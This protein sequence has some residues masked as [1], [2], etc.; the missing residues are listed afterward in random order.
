M[1]DFKVNDII[2]S[3]LFDGRNKYPLTKYLIVGVTDKDITVRALTGAFKNTYS[4]AS[5]QYFKDYFKVIA[6]F[7]DRKVDKS[8]FKPNCCV[9][10]INSNLPENIGK[11]ALF[12]SNVNPPV[13][14]NGVWNDCIV[15]VEG[16]TKYTLLPKSWIKRIHKCKRIKKVGERNTDK[17]VPLL[18]IFSMDKATVVEK[19][20][21]Y[22]MEDDKVCIYKKDVFE[23][24]C[25]KNDEYDE[26]TGILIALAR[27]YKDEVLE[28]FALRRDF[29]NSV[30]MLTKG[31]KN[32][33]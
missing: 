32:D 4:T 14:H 25:H 1:S 27:T 21:E 33:K 30:A 7:K 18:K 22:T 16:Y 11:K 17:Y 24:R 23:A 28:D 10:V 20:K 9:E 31:M 8:A 19:I 26:L 2:Q 3:K 13:F 29:Y 12:I 6:H 5:K 15:K